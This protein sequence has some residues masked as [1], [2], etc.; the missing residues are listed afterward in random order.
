M[1]ASASGATA[2]AAARRSSSPE[3]CST[4]RTGPE[5]SSCSY[6]A[7]CASPN[8][9]SSAR[10]RT[11]LP[12][13]RAGVLGSSEAACTLVAVCTQERTRTMPVSTTVAAS[14]RLSFVF[15]VIA[16]RSVG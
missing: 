3:A 5:D 4:A 2:T 12:G 9:I 15:I 7:G 10:A 1:S 13:T 8:S 16:L 11:R 6:G 14:Q